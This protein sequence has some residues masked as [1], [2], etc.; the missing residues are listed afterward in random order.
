MEQYGNDCYCTTVKL[1]L[2]MK[3]KCRT[4]EDITIDMA[5]IV[6]DRKCNC[7]LFIARQ[8]TAADT[9]VSYENGLTYCHSIFTI[10]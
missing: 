10:R 9:L 1:T 5:R 3:A 4:D 2:N 8:H 6:K 7:T